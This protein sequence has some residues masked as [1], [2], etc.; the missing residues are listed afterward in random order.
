MARLKVLFTA[1]AV[2]R[3][4]A[5]AETSIINL[6]GIAFDFVA[7]IL[8]VNTADF[9]LHTPGFGFQKFLQP[10]EFGN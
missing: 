2:D 4:S 8:A 1:V 6:R 10:F 7:M 5:L 9:T 3:D